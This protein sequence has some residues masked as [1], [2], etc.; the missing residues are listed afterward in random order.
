MNSELTFK[1][2]ELFDNPDFEIQFDACEDRESIRNLFSAKGV[3]FTGEEF[4]SFINEAVKTEKNDELDE[5]ALEA[6]SGGG[7]IWNAIKACVKD[8]AKSLKKALLGSPKD[9]FN[10]GYKFEKKWGG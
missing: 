8:Y 4:E 9:A 10:E 1:V 3:Q 6:V 5:S 2:A 7:K